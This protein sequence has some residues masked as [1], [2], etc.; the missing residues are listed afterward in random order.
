ME[1]VYSRQTLPKSIF[2]AGP[3]P[4]PPKG[5]G[6][7]EPSWRPLAVKILRELGF[8]GTVFVPED[9][10][11]SPKFDYDDQVEW[12][13]QALSSAT[14]VVFWIPRTETMPAFTTNVEYGMFISKPNTVVGA[15]PEAEKMKYLE[16][17]AAVYG[18]EVYK[19]LIT[20]LS[21][22]IAKTEG[23]TKTF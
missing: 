21:V 12:E 4:R 2:L 13:L 19:D 7:K 10:G 20:T 8:E 11:D 14:V 17:L 6:V 18:K 9:A 16:R 15:P 1:V 23:W 3:T 5:G 22:A